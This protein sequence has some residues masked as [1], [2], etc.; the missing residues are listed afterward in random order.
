M[1]GAGE[2]RVSSTRREV[3][4]E[5]ARTVIERVPSVYLPIARKRTPKRT[6]LDSSTDLL[7][8]GFPR[9]GNTFLLAWIARANPDLRIA[10]HM[11]S[12]ANV[13]A[14]LRSGVPVVVVI[15][16]PEAAIA[17]LAVYNPSGPLDQHVARYGRFH[18]GVLDVV[19]DVILSPFP[20]TTRVP[21]R[22]VE[23]IVSR[24]GRPLATS[25]AGGR[26]E[27]LAAVDDRNVLFN[28]ELIE[29]KVS[30]PS[31]ARRAATE[32]VAA[33]LRERFGRELQ[34]LDELHHVL[35]RASSAVVADLPSERSLP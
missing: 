14:A 3:V 28:G 6:A 29:L 30:R 7:I 19:D 34:E 12:I 8:E 33:V 13:R 21:E 2:L 32:A 9:S 25:P 31:E 5:R 15:R 17:S 23:A 24:S 35:T 18:R 11:H 26:D 1:T 22:V 27:V 20:V 16:P 10:S 4:A